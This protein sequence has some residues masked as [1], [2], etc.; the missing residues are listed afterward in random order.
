MGTAFGS[1]YKEHEKQGP[2]SGNGAST[3]TTTRSVENLVEL[4][5][6]EGTSHQGLGDHVNV[7]VLLHEHLVDRE[8]GETELVEG[9]EGVA[10]GLVLLGLRSLHVDLLGGLGIDADSALH[11][12]VGGRLLVLNHGLVNLLSDFILV[13]FLGL[14][15]LLVSGNLDDGLLGNHGN[16][17]DSLLDGVRQKAERILSINLLG[18]SLNNKDRVAES[19][20]E[21][22]LA[23]LEAEVRVVLAKLGGCLAHHRELKGLTGGHGHL[24]VDHGG[25][26]VIA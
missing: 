4:A 8:V 5:L 12:G 17:V 18:L 15:N 21:L 11:Q 7:L 2:R 19:V 1:P 13:D 25:G 24:Q 14:S 22:D 26:D 20:A 6:A 10:E 23:G 9:L 3:V 16:R